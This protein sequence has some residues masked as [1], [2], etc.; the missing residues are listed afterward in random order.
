MNSTLKRFTAR[1]FFGAACIISL[2]MLL[3]AVSPAAA[4]PTVPVLWTAGGHSAGSDSAG[5]AAHVATDASGNITVVSGPGF[6]GRLVVTS[7]TSTGALRWQ[8]SVAPL[9]GT[10]SANWVA[11]APNGDVV[12]LGSTADSH[13]RPYAITLVR[14][15]SDGTLLWRVDP[16]NL[17]F[18]FAVGRVLVDAAG[19][20]YVTF[21]NEVDKYS[22]SGVFL[23]AQTIPA[24]FAHSMALG[25]DGSDVVVTGNF[26]AG[27]VWVTASVDAA[28]GASRWSVTASEGIAAR[29]VVVDSSRAYVAGE[30]Y[31]GAGTPEL[32]YFLTVVAYDRTTGARLWRTDK[33]PAM[34]QA[35]G[36][37]WQ[38]LPTGAS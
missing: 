32:A 38:R 31:T 36:F 17:I 28:T 7:Y 16:P 13:G 12:A 9:A 34:V 11:A 30:G 18:Q 26:L 8:R 6:F 33:I 29:D 3:G 23:W 10:M 1:G 2:A 25:P 22:A 15:A 19:N 24:T 20:V 37:G 27:S 35:A 5:Q 4:V 14:Y 21:N